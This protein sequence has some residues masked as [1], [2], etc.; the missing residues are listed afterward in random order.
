M[1]VQDFKI[2]ILSGINDNPQEPN[3]NNNNRGPNGSYFTMKFNSLVDYLVGSK[4]Y[5]SDFKILG[6]EDSNILE[7]GNSLLWDSHL[8]EIEYSLNNINDIDQVNLY[9]DDTLIVTDLP[10]ASNNI[11][12]LENINPAYLYKDTES[13]V[14]W[15]IEVLVSGDRFARELKF[16]WRFKTIVGFS[17]RGDII[18]FNDSRLA[19]S[20]INSVLDR[21]DTLRK[22]YSEESLYTYIFLPNIYT[23]YEEFRINGFKVGMNES[24]QNIFYFGESRS[25]TVYRSFYPTKGTYTLHLI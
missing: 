3:Y 22:S 5:I 19:V 25:Y 24:Q 21:P 18:D 4:S 9:A 11:Y 23:N 15:K 12:S 14:I 17:E 8:L 10:K 2:P 20:S 16:S 1:S 13:E 7:I 6:Y